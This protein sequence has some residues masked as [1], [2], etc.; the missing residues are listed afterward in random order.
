MI[1]WG[2][3]PSTKYGIGSEADQTHAFK[4]PIKYDS[5]YHLPFDV[6]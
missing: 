2:L 4:S 1:P 5:P 3:I 6:S